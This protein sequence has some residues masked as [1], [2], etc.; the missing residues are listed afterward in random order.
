MKKLAEVEA[1]PSGVRALGIMP[2]LSC[3]IQGFIIQS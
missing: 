2:L 1:R 3:E